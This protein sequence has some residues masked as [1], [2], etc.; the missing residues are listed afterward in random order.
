MSGEADRAPGCVNYSRQS[1]DRFKQAF[2]NISASLS[3]DSG[4]FLALI[5]HNQSGT[6]RN[7]QFRDNRGVFKVIPIDTND[8]DCCI[9]GVTVD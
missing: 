6:T 2:N 8:S 9:L 7:I 4:D 1:G 3:D 5:E